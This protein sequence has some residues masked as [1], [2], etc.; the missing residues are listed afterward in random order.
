MSPLKHWACQQIAHPI[1]NGS[2]VMDLYPNVSCAHAWGKTGKQK[3]NK[4]SQRKCI[5]AFIIQKCWSRLHRACLGKNR[6]PREKVSFLH[7]RQCWDLQL[8]DSLCASVRD[9]QSNRS[10]WKA[11]SPAWWRKGFV[12]AWNHNKLK[13]GLRE[14]GLFDCLN[15]PSSHQCEI[16]ENLYPSKDLLNIKIITW[17]IIIP[18][19]FSTSQWQYCVTDLQQFLLIA[20]VKYSYISNLNYSKLLKQI[21]T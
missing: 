17:L 16:W 3:T 11:D 8:N 14:R 20:K 10:T 9:I 21:Q 13:K 19:I 18:W 1:T 2:K 6:R 7:T 5:R 15:S 4:F 12:S